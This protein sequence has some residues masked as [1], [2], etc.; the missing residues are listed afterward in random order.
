[1]NSY[2]CEDEFDEFDYFDDQG[3]RVDE[4]GNL[5]LDPFIPKVPRIIPGYMV[6]HKLVKGKC[7]WC[8]EPPASAEYE[9]WNKNPAFILESRNKQP[10]QYLL[11]IYCYDYAVLSVTTE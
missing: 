8:E 5:I 4:F 6:V 7:A 2:Y 11:H 3:R 1:M 10:A 9:L